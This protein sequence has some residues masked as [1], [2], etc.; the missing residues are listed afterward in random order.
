MSPEYTGGRHEPEADLGHGTRGTCEPDAPGASPP[1]DSAITGE[2]AIPDDEINAAP[3]G[4][5]AGQ[6]VPLRDGFKV[7]ED[8]VF[9]FQGHKRVRTVEHGDD[10]S[11]HIGGRDGTTYDDRQELTHLD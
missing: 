5:V 9:T 10:D 2:N 3:R 1:R 6:G 7:F 8:P 11:I 4:T